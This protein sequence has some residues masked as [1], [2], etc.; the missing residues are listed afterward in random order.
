MLLVVAIF[1]RSL[2]TIGFKDWAFASETTNAK[3]N[4]SANNFPFVCFMFKL[5]EW[6]YQNL[7]NDYL[8][9]LHQRKK[10]NK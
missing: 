3:K 8:S 1:I 4:T 10:E 2:T 7:P 9:F 5:F 6:K